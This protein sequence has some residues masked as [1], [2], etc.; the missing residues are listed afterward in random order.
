MELPGDVLRAERLSRGL[1]L[2]DVSTETKIGLHLLQAIEENRFDL[3]PGG[4]FTRSFLRQYASA[5]K[6]NDE[7]IFASFD[8]QF[9]EA[10][11]PLP[12]PLPQVSRPKM[13][14]LPTCG[15]FAITIVL[16]GAA[17]GLWQNARAGLQDTNP[18]PQHHLQQQAQSDAVSPLTPTRRLSTQG[19]THIEEPTPLPVPA[20]GMHIVFTAIEPVWLSVQCDGHQV[21]AGTLEEKQTKNIDASTKMVALIGN[22]A[23]LGVSLNGKELGPIGQHGEVRV[24]EMTPAGTHIGTRRSANG[25][26]VP[27]G[28]ESTNTPKQL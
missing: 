10:P 15:W 4:L 21:F 24:L 7:R 12:P 13:R 20:G 6:I 25:P 8:K 1:R 17:Y 2:E 3:L 28:S 26:I 9:N 22:A 16:G 11:L 19:P 14:F 5:L 23:G 18:A 27:E